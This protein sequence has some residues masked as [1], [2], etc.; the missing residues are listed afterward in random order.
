MVDNPFP[1]NPPPRRSDGF[2]EIPPSLFAILIVDLVGTV[3]AG[4]SL[5]MVLDSEQALIPRSS[6][7]PQFAAGGLALGILLMVF[8]GYL[9]IKRLRLLRE[10]AAVGGGHDT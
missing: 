6:G 3:V 2:A 4:L 10:Q 9:L 5:Y 7:I 8:A 1:V